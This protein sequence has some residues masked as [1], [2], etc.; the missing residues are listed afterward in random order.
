MYGY[1]FK[2]FKV[3][4]CSE[5]GTLLPE[6]S[7]LLPKTVRILVVQQPRHTPVTQERERSRKVPK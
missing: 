7:G 1:Y 4:I 5:N 2:Q 6:R 3:R